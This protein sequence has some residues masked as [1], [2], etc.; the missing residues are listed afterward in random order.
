MDREYIPQPDI[1]KR[2][3]K[4]SLPRYDLKRN[5]PAPDSTWS[6][7]SPIKTT[8]ALFSPQSPRFVDFYNSHRINRD[9]PAPTLGFHS[10]KKVPFSENDSSP[11]V[12]ENNDM[13]KEETGIIKE[14]DFK[15]F[16]EEKNQA[17]KKSTLL[18]PKEFENV[19]LKYRPF[20]SFGMFRKPKE[21]SNNNPSNANESNS[22]TN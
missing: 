14:P 6:D 15:S 19:I 7:Y 5:I 13:K 12:E 9:K 11:N 21:K 20:G 2:P 16:V 17:A 1:P 3:P 22:T 4:I 18:M 10:P 8:P